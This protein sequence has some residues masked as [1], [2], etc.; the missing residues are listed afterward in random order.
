M[1]T[2]QAISFMEKDINSKR[3]L[4]NLNE[5]SFHAKVGK[6]TFFID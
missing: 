1:M 2:T 4:I 3:D 6:L 5:I